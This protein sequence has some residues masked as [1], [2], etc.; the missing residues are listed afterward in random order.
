[1]SNLYKKAT[2][3][4]IVIRKKVY[5]QTS[6]ILNFCDN[7]FS[8]YAF[9]THDEEDI[10]KV[11]YHIVGITRAQIRLSTLLNKLVDYFKFDNPFGIEIEIAYSLEG[12]IQYLTHKNQTEKKQY[13]YEDIHIHW[14]DKEEFKLLYEMTIKE[15]EITT[16]FL[17][18]CIKDCALENDY[19]GNSIVCIP[20]LLQVL[21]LKNFNKY[22]G[23]IKMIINYIE[24][25]RR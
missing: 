19:Y 6:D 15:K 22:Q 20:Q 11:H 9:I 7:H 21:G 14:N 25:P 3:F 2:K 13:K 16:R 4:N 23:V 17:Y 8:N 5:L 10:N 24:R 12:S 1:M 18:D